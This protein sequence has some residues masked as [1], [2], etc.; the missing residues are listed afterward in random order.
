MSESR[1]E[2]TKFEFMYKY[3]GKSEKEKISS[4]SVDRDFSPSILSI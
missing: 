2:I 3:N 4:I 1:K